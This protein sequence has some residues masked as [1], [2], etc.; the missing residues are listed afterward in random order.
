MA[1][2]PPHFSFQTITPL[3]PGK[4]WLLEGSYH[5]ADRPPPSSGLTA[6]NPETY[7]HV[8]RLDHWLLVFSAPVL[9][10]LSGTSSHMVRPA[11]TDRSVPWPQR[12]KGF[13]LLS[14][15]DSS[16]HGHTYPLSSPEAMQSANTHTQPHYPPRSL[17]QVLPRAVL[18]SQGHHQLMKLFTLY[19]ICSPSFHNPREH[20]MSE[21]VWKA[22]VSCTGCTHVRHYFW[23][24]TAGLKAGCC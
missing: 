20:Q 19:N 5:L 15:S 24:R 22:F 9:S 6:T 21:D 16:S 12:S 14:C 18:P 1:S 10:S 3:P 17:A 4:L 2:F 23:C 13:F 7:P 8:R 11:D